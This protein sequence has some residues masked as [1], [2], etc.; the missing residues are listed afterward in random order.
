MGSKQLNQWNYKETITTTFN[1]DT[2]V[3]QKCTRNQHCK[4]TGNPCSAVNIARHGKK[5]ILAPTHN[6]NIPIFDSGGT[7]IPAAPMAHKRQFVQPPRAG[8]TTARNTTK[9][10]LL[11]YV[12]TLAMTKNLVIY[13]DPGV[14]PRDD[15][16]EIMRHNNE[17]IQRNDKRTINKKTLFQLLSP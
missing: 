5:K 8:M 2:L 9:H 15:I 14:K 10:Y 17:V 16:R 6:S 13:L 7:V 3:C 1:W 4:K 12:A 11:N